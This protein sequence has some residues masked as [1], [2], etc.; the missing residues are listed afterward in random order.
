MLFFDANGLIAFLITE[1][2]LLFGGLNLANLMYGLLFGTI[3]GIIVTYLAR[4]QAIKPGWS[5]KFFW[6]NLVVSLP[7][8]FTFALIT[9]WGYS[10][11]SFL[12]FVFIYEGFFATSM[13]L[14]LTLGKEIVPVDL[15]WSFSSVKRNFV[16]V[17]DISGIITWVLILILLIFSSIFEPNQIFKG[18]Y[19]ESSGQITFIF[20]L[21]IIGL[22]FILLLGSLL[23][24][25]LMSLIIAC[26]AIPISGFSNRS[27]EKSQQNRSKRGIWRSFLSSFLIF[28]LSL[29]SITIVWGVI[30]TGGKATSSFISNLPAGFLTALPFGLAIATIVAVFYGGAATLKHGILRLILFFS[31]DIPWN[32]AHFL[33]FATDRS[34]LK[35]VEEG[36]EFLHPLFL[37]HF[38]SKTIQLASTEDSIQQ[39]AHK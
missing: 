37:E 25:G 11:S 30:V 1:P 17:R 36:Y 5:W 38:M 9:G 7:I 20:I 24:A 16:K 23:G 29:I 35:Q 19:G 3:Q 21:K 33:A 34:I 4:S 39:S 14:V 15:V 8:V 31:Q 2:F 18:I 28:F 10:F 32:Y 26:S 12:L 13:S 27:L 6:Q 22:P